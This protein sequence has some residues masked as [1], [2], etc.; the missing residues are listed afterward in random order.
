MDGMWTVC[1]MSDLAIDPE[2]WSSF[3]IE[4]FCMLCNNVSAN[5]IRSCEYVRFVNSA[6]Q[7]FRFSPILYCALT[8]NPVMRFSM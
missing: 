1:P 2:M 6:L 7:L 4:L 5:S 3:S 8:S